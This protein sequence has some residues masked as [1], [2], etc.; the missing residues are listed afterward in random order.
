MASTISTD[1]LLMD[2]LLDWDHKYAYLQIYSSEMTAEYEKIKLY[3]YWINLI[4][5]VPQYRKL[6]K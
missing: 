1:P 2:I 4:A 5:S 6:Q 3:L